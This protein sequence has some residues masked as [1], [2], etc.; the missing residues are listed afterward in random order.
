VIKLSTVILAIF[1][2]FMGTDA[3]ALVDVP[4]LR[5]GIGQSPL[6]F[7]AGTAFKDAKLG[8][9]LVLNPMFLWDAPSLRTRIGF[10]FLADLGTKYGA[11]ATA[12]VGVTA[13]FYPLGLSSSRE[14]RDDFSEVVKTRLSPYMQFSITPTKFSVTQ[15][16]DPTSP[17]FNVPN[18]WPYF[19]SRIVEV[20]IGFGLDYPLGDDLVA[21]G[22]IHFRNAAISTQESNADNKGDINYGGMA[23]IFGIMTNFY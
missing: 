11:V 15:T 17:L 7:N 5:L 23:L 9:T 4:T 12:G 1:L 6:T 10:H 2:T 19:S 13:I 3:R 16:P 20:S 18:Q 8:G 21:F 14:V 22:G